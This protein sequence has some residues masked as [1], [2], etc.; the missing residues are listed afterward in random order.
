MLIQSSALFLFSPLLVFAFSSPAH[1]NP[2]P[3]DGLCWFDLSFD[4]TYPDWQHIV[5]G[6]IW[7]PEMAISAIVARDSVNLR[8]GAGTENP[9]IQ[10]LS[11]NTEVTLRGY[12][13]ASDCDTEN[14]WFRVE[15]PY[16][17]VVGWV[18]ADMLVAKNSIDFARGF[19]F[20]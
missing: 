11:Q 6:R 18:R 17:G 12:A 7:E 3:D 5:P 1:A 14:F 19:F 20:W 9:S 2:N 4:P 16:T 13:I 15:L 10:S 8:S